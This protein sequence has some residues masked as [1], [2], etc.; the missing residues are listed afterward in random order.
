M[1]RRLEVMAVAEFTHDMAETLTAVFTAYAVEGV[2]R[3][4]V[5]SHGLWLIHPGGSR[6]FLGAARL[7]EPE[8]KNVQH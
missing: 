5:T 1:A 8:S 2:V 4:E 7:P 3:L 6:Q